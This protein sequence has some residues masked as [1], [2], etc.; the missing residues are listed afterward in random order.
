MMSRTV[1]R[2]AGS[3]VLAIRAQPQERRA[4]RTALAAGETVSVALYLGPQREQLGL[5]LR[6][7]MAIER[8]HGKTW[9]E[10][11]RLQRIGLAAM[12][13]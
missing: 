8:E 12:P 9:R 3:S 2:S 11:A 10:N 6:G 1:A 7:L 4:A 5:V 13:R